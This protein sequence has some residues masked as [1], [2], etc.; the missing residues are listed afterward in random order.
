[1]KDLVE[2][3]SFLAIALL[4][5]VIPIYVLSVSLLGQAIERSRKAREDAER[6]QKIEMDTKIQQLQDQLEQARSTGDVQG[7]SE[8]PTQMARLRKNGR[9][10]LRKAERF[11]RA[12]SLMGAVAYPGIGFL[13]AAFLSAGSTLLCES[14]IG[15]TEIP[16]AVIPWAGS[17]IALAYGILKLIETLRVV[18][19]VALVSEET[20]LRRTIDAF[21][22]AQRELDEEKK[23]LL[24]FSWRS[25]QPPFS[26][27]AGG[28]ITLHYA[29][30]FQ[31]GESARQASVWFFAPEGFEFPKRSTW[32]QDDG[33]GEISGMLTTKDT[34]DDTIVRGVTYNRSI[35]LTSPLEEGTYELRVQVMC[36]GYS[37]EYVA[38][39]VRVTPPEV[40]D[41]TP[42]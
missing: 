7:I 5:L 32:L 40:S 13:V 25:P 41:D 20:A 22:H 29:V 1:M 3:T 38:F 18:Q 28:E 33:L 14:R 31:R 2:A 6:Q 4:A 39:E 17:L 16:Y 19:Q 10:V 27:P 24:R 42:F 9:R 30:Q 21:K 37:G 12:L 23:P 8:I 15:S 35:R 36:I 34:L 11:S 26:V